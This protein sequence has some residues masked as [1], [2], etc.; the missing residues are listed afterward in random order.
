MFIPLTI[1]SSMLYV[2]LI[3]SRHVIGK[4]I[5]KPA[6]TI[7][8]IG[9]AHES[10]PVRNDIKLAGLLLSLLGDIFLMF[11]GDLNFVLGLL[12][13]LSAHILYIKSFN[14]TRKTQQNLS[15]LAVLTAIGVSYFSYLF[16]YIYKDGGYVLVVGVFVYVS[17]IVGMAYTAL[18]NGNTPL[19]IGV[20]MFMI[21]DS[22]L[23][24][25]KFVT[26]SPGIAYEVTVMIT[27]HIAQFCI[28]NY[29]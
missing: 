25:D 22:V 8:I 1:L 10:S 23:A 2:F 27:Y 16:N 29:H 15:A 12:S 5:V 18:L 24:F 3:H 4:Y 6:T 14:K 7:L 17:A 21:S 19:S 20:A 26:Q 9:V 28:A 13:F 11:E